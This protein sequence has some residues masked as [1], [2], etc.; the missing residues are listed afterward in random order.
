MREETRAPTFDLAVFAPRR[1]EVLR[2]TVAPADNAVAG[3]GV[4]G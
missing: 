1:G 2:V 4:R 3:R